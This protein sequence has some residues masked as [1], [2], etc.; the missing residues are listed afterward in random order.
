[1]LSFIRQVNH[2][3]SKSQKSSL[4]TVYLNFSRVFFVAGMTVSICNC[5]EHIDDGF[6]L[7]LDNSNIIGLNR[8]TFIGPFAKLPKVIFEATRSKYFPW[9]YSINSIFD[10]KP[11]NPFSSYRLGISS[12]VTWLLI[13]FLLKSS[14]PILHF[15]S[16]LGNFFTWKQKLCAF[17]LYIFWR[18]NFIFVGSIPTLYN[19]FLICLQDILWSHDDAMWTY[20]LFVMSWK[21]FGL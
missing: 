13:K 15:I 12:K 1:M 21:I 6:I 17:V 4:P 18:S 10:K 11:R 5:N 7:T 20:I 19:I 9:F 8:T 2:R 3:Y 16:E 14:I